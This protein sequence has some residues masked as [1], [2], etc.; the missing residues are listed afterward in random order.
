[1]AAAVPPVAVPPVTVAPAPG[2]K[3]TTVA[4]GA[5]ERGA[6]VGLA[7]LVAALCIAVIALRPLAGTRRKRRS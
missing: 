4:G 2:D 5:V 6:P 7:V 1:V 3:P